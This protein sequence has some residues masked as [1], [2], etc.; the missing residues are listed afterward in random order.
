[1]VRDAYVGSAFFD[2]AASAFIMP[3]LQQRA[4]SSSSSQTTFDNT[5]ST[6]NDALTSSA[7]GGYGLGPEW[8]TKSGFGARNKASDQYDLDGRGSGS[9]EVPRC[10][11]VHN[12]F[13]ITSMS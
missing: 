9:L 1:V 2:A 7:Y 11:F 8:V 5:K 4:S 13:V 10:L 6:T 3:S 12:Q